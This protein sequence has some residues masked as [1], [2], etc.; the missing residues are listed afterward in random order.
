MDKLHKQKQRRTFLTKATQTAAAAF[1]VGGGRSWSVSAEGGEIAAN[2]EAASAKSVSP[3]R[4]GVLPG[5]FRTGSLAARLDAVKAN[6]LDCVQ[7][8]MDCAGLQMMPD[9]IAPE[10]PNPQSWVDDEQKRA[11]SPSALPACQR[12]GVRSRPR[13]WAVAKAERALVSSQN[14]SRS[15][16]SG[17]CHDDSGDDL[18]RG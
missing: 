18:V 17:V 1:V 16:V 5:T 11:V 14:P 7:L 10:C 15:V 13:S 3:I 6:G 8:S 2:P 4:I 12:G 9:E